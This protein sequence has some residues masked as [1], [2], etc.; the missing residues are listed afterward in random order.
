MP[1]A[2]WVVKQR[3]VGSIKTPAATR[4]RKHSDS[5]SRTNFESM[6]EPTNFTNKIS[7]PKIVQ[8]LALVFSLVCIFGCSSIMVRPSP[9]GR[10]DLQG[11]PAND[12]IAAL[13]ASQADLRSL[14][15]LGKIRVSTPENRLRASQVVLVQSPDA[16]R[17][18]VL[19]PFGISY[20]IAADGE[21]LT[22][23]STQDNVLYRGRPDQQTI[24][25]V[26]GIA[27]APRD[28]TSLLL[29]RACKG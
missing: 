29:G 17:I 26:I 11:I 6:V 7:E 24:A 3:H 8:R 21:A 15:A 18:E 27:L 1:I 4:P 9:E 25:E 16:F 28:M 10:P 14:D 22:T 23:L 2:V 12:L 13:R 20:V 19:A 5:A